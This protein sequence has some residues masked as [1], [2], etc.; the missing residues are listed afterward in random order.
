MQHKNVLITGA[1]SGMGLATSIEMAKQGYDV[2][3][4]CRNEERG[5]EALREA[6]MKSG[7]DHITL[8]MCDLSSLDSIR[9]FVYTFKSLYNKLDVL[10]NNAGVVTINRETTKNGFEKMFGVNHLGH[11]LLTN[12]LLDDIQASE[13]GRIIVLSSGA[14][15]IGKIHFENL[16]LIKG[17]NVF[18]GYA[19]SKLAN[20][21]FTRELSK[22]LEDTNITVNAVHPGAVS[23]SLGVNR[24]TGFGRMLH[25]LLRPFFQS[26]SKGAETAIYLATSREVRNVS[27]QYF[28]K[29]KKQEL[30]SRG[31]DFIIA[32]KLWE[33]SN[34]EVN[35]TVE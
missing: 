9:D 29:K 21:L 19:Q 15:K 33:R 10:I 17:F 30:N 22:R 13:Q 23:T 14:Y 5:K 1:N 6:K 32:G 25:T 24:E 12:L 2:I 7:S 26:P 35:L 16:S 18:K 4:A 28:Y 27:G 3:M 20:I 11:F 8:M 34:Q 31:K